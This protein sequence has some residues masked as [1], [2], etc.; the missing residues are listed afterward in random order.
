MSKK[1]HTTMKSK[2][3]NSLL[4]VESS[5]AICLIMYIASY[6]DTQLPHIV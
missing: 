4:P 1:L 6:D 5:K 3:I 2:I